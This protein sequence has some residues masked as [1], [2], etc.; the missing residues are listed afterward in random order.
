MADGSTAVWV[1]TG[2]YDESAG[3]LSYSDGM[4]QVQSAE[5]L[6]TAYQN[7]KGTLT[8]KD[9]ALVWKDGNESKS[10]TFQRDES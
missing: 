9:G 7:S 3:V 8:V 5:G 2:H 10:I 1:F 6:K 4:K